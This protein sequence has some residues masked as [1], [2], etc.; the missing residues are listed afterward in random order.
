[1]TKKAICIIFIVLFGFTLVT[2]LIKSEHYDPFL[3]AHLTLSDYTNDVGYLENSP[4]V[5]GD[6]GDMHVQMNG[7]S[8]KFGMT[9]IVSFLQLFSGLDFLDLALIPLGVIICFLSVYILIREIFKEGLDN[10]NNFLVFLCSFF[11]IFF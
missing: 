9:I 5:D 2:Y 3:T 7:I 8:N 4:F 11:F 10:K 6:R 1:M